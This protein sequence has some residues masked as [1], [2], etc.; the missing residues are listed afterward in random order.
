M[1][2]ICVLEK[3]DGQLKI[4]FMYKLPPYPLSLFNEKDMRKGI[5]ANPYKIFPECESPDLKNITYV[6]DGGGG[7]LLQKV[8]WEQKQTDSE[9]CE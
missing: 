4:D 7:Y 3:S 1:Y 2:S 6:L 5:N 8:L 9:I